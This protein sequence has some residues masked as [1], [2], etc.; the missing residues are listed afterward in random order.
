MGD[1]DTTLEIQR[2]ALLSG[3]SLKD[4]QERD[5]QTAFRSHS[6]LKPSNLLMHSHQRFIRLLSIEINSVLERFAFPLS[7]A[8]TRF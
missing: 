2:P 1:S 8:L 5:L 6:S 3:N 4:S 7:K